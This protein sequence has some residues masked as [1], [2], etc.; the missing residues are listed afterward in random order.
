M[1][2]ASHVTILGWSECTLL[3]RIVRRINAIWGNFCPK[4]HCFG[5]FSGARAHHQGLVW[6]KPCQFQRNVYWYCEFDNLRSAAQFQLLTVYSSLTRGRRANEHCL[7][8]P[9][10]LFFY[11]L[12]FS[13]F[14]S[15]KFF[16]HS[17]QNTQYWVLVKNAWFCKSQLFRFLSL[18]IINASQPH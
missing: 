6:L 7:T 3:G 17:R 15:G 18:R 1:M 10:F 13:S 11:V 2:A 9:T 12:N 4:L 8:R 5:T 16:L 14:L